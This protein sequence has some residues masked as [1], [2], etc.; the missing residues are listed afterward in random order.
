MKKLLLSH[1]RSYLRV[2]THSNLLRSHKC[3]F[4][5]RIHPDQTVAHE[6]RRLLSRL[7][8]EEV[9]SQ[10]IPRYRDYTRCIATC[11]RFLLFCSIDWNRKAL[12]LTIFNVSIHLRLGRPTSI[13]WSQEIVLLSKIFWLL[14]RNLQHYRHK[15]C[16]LCI[17]YLATCKEDWSTCY[18]KRLT[19]RLYTN[20]L[21]WRAYVLSYSLHLFFPATSSQ[22]CSIDLTRNIVEYEKTVAAMLSSSILPYQPVKII[23]MSLR[24]FYSSS[25]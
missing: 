7:L 16:L 24:S 3:S 14:S 17:L 22:A 1:H 2:G 4:L 12:H 8:S 9:Y 19:K 6:R 18:R 13:C 10:S 21:M 20:S 5:G 23:I 25:V 11:L 15:Y